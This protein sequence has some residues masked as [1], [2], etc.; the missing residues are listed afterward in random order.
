MADGD[1]DKLKYYTLATKM[2]YEFYTGYFESG[3][4]RKLQAAYDGVKLPILYAPA[5]GEQRGVI[6]LHGG[7]DSYLE[8]FF[9]PVR[10]LAQNGCSVYLYEGPGQ[11]GVVR[12][13]GK[14]FTYQWEKPTKAVLDAVGETD[15]TIMG[16]SLGGMPAPRR[17]CL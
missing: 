7:N 2:F 6:L 11:G 1:P 8:E 14:K 5:Q 10:Y 17:R 4:V 16:A 13:Q 3:A 12:G 15:V 9:F